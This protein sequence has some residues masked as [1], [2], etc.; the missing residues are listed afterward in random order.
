MP[1]KKRRN[2]Q[3]R[4]SRFP[5]FTLCHFLFLLIS[6][7]QA[8]ADAYYVLSDPTRRKEY[9]AL[10]ASHA[11]SERS[12]EPNAFFANFAQM[13]AGT[14]SERTGRNARAEGFG[15]GQRPDAEGVFGDVFEEVNF[16]VPSAPFLFSHLYVRYLQLLRPEIDR[17]VQWWTY[18]GT[19]SGGA[20]GYI[21]G[22]LPGMVNLDSRND[23][24]ADRADRALTAVWRVCWK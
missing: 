12:T 24:S 3:R 20:L 15:E 21:I 16:F 2:A 18:V 10:Y 23:I 17:R 9:D 5:H 13:F 19:A 14:A 11:A 4:N 22:N 6:D 8:V 1:H 7:P